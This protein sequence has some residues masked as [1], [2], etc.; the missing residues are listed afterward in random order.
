PAGGVASA[1]SGAQDETSTLDPQVPVASK[2]GMAQ[3]L[4]AYASEGWEAQWTCE[5][6]AT[7][8]TTDGSAAEI[9]VHGASNR[10]CNNTLL[11]NAQLA[12]GAELPVGAAALKY[13]G[14]D[15]YAEVKVAAASDGGN[16][17][18]WYAPGGAVA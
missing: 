17:W 6:T 3:W 15:I 10:V 11:A 12:A 7:D 13:V 8:K 2:E 4:A 9:H 1:G 5:A 18:F 16:G 14:A